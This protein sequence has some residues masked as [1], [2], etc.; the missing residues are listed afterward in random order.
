MGDPPEDDCGARIITP[1]NPRRHYLLAADP[2]DFGKKGDPSAFTIWD[3]T[4]FE[5]V[6]FWEGREQPDLFHTRCKKAAI[7]YNDALL[8][9]ESNCSAVIGIAYTDDDEDLPELYYDQSDK[10]GWRA[11]TKSLQEAEGSLNIMLRDGSLTI[12]A[13]STVL[14][15]L[16]FD[17]LPRDR[18]IRKDNGEQSHGDRARTVVMA[19]RFMEQGG[20]MPEITLEELAALRAEKALQAQIAKDAAYRRQLAAFGIRPPGGG[21]SDNP[22]APGAG[23]NGL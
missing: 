2:A 8:M 19:A 18:R 6:A 21:A 5:E 20:Y 22:W 15:L 16:L 10:P 14:Q 3:L 7:H 23:R 12:K 13:K 1:S 17:G 4:T 9:Y 11:T